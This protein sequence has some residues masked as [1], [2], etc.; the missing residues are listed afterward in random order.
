MAFH[1]VKDDQILSQTRIQIPTYF[2]NNM[3]FSLQLFLLLVVLLVRI[4]EQSP[5]MIQSPTL[6]AT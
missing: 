6:F 2:F 4:I 5:I 1:M 3:S